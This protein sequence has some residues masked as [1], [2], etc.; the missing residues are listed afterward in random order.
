M[1]HQ[2]PVWS[3]RINCVCSSHKFCSAVVNVM[4]AK[5]INILAGE[6]L[7]RIINGFLT[8]WDF[9]QCI[10]AIDSN[11]IPIIAQKEH[12]LDYFNRK[13]YH[14]VLL[15]APVDHKLRFLDIYVGWPHRV[16]MADTRT[17]EI[18]GDK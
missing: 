16:V 12:P 2:S 3:W 5:Y 13:G 9:P 6:H 10:G 7:K 18:Q 11:H 14:S 15:Q 1:N 4:T 8:K 17:L